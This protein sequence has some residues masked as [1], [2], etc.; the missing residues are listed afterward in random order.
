MPMKKALA[1][2]LFAVIAAFAPVA[3]RAGGFEIGVGA[4]YWYSVK[5][6]V[7]DSFDRDGLGWMITSKIMFDYWGIGL[8]YEKSPDNFV[9]LEEPV[10]YPAVYLILGNRLYAAAGIGT[11]YYDGDFID[12]TWYSFRVGI[13][14]PFLLPCLTIDINANYRIEKWSEMNKRDFDSDNI[15]LG[16]ALRLTF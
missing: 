8:E 10:Y 3:A 15:I 1:I 12:D 11:Y 4:N 14:G 9:S 2:A 6:A 5:D 16:A 7:D 13:E